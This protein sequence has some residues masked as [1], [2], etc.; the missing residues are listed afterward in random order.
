MQKIISPFNIPD[1]QLNR[2]SLKHTNQRN[3]MCP[4]CQKRFKSKATC[5]THLQIHKNEWVKQFKEQL[6]SGAIQFEQDISDIPLTNHSNDITVPNIM[7]PSTN[8]AILEVLNGASI[9]SNSETVHNIQEHNQVLFTNLVQETQT[10][11]SRNQF[12]Y[13]L[14]LPT[15]SDGNNVGVDSEG[16]AETGQFILND[17]QLNFSNLQ[18]IQLEQSGL[19]EMENSQAIPVISSYRI[20]DNQSVE[21]R[22]LDQQMETNAECVNNVSDESLPASVP[23]VEPEEVTSN[24]T[25][26]E[27]NQIALTNKNS[28][29][30]RKRKSTK[31]INKCETCSKVFQKPIDLRRHIRTH[32]LEKV[33]KEVSLDCRLKYFFNFVFSLSVVPSARKRSV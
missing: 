16:R 33:I 19:L 18:F 17:E 8:E 32:T 6:K 1:N 24:V 3:V 26:C 13:F 21:R 23:V 11:D 4:Y 28:S 22:V 14:L 27:T 2:H 10:D 29:T 5:R 12:E 25:T 31:S 30:N 9:D 7:T 20:D 15:N